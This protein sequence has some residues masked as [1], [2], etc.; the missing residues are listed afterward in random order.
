[1]HDN[2]RIENLLVIGGPRGPN[3]EDD[4]L[5]TTSPSEEERTRFR[6]T[7]PNVRNDLSTL[8]HG[9]RYAFIAIT[10]FRVSV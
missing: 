8:V 4:P 6:L 2:A 10:A 7:V 5:R 1:L 9:S 3:I